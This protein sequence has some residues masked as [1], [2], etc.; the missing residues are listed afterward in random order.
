MRN[1]MGTADYKAYVTDCYSNPR[2]L[3]Q[4]EQDKAEALQSGKDRR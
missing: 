3:E 4:T 1:G 2:S